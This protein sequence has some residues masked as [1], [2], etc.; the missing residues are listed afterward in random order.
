MKL[1]NYALF[2]SS[3]PDDSVEVE[4]N[5]E[6]PAGR[7]VMESLAQRFKESGVQTSVVSQHSFYGWSFEAR[8]SDRAF[9]FLLQH[10]APWLLLVQDRRWLLRRW[11]EGQATFHGALKT[12]DAALRALGHVSALEWLTQS[13]YEARGRAEFE[14]RKKQPYERPKTTKPGGRDSA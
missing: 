5:I 14:K 6:V 12:C 9:W 4:E 10:P 13:E 2:E 11:L 1:P 3:L 7:N 8:I